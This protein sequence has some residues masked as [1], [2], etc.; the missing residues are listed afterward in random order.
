MEHKSYDLELELKG[1]DGGEFSAYFATFHDVDKV[2]DRIEPGAFKNLDDFV[3]SGW[4]GLNHEHARLPVAY[5]VSAVQ[6]AKGLLVTGRYHSTP[7]AQ[8]VR[9]VVRER[10]ESGKS[11]KGSIGYGVI[12][13]TGSEKI[14]V[15]GKSVRSLKE[16]DLAECS[17]VNRPANPNAEVVHSKSLIS[18]DEIREYIDEIKAG[19]VLS[20]ANLSV[21]AG[22]DNSVA[23]LHGQIRALRTEHD[24]ALKPIFDIP[25]SAPADVAALRTQHLALCAKFGLYP[26]SP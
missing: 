17:F 23:E 21:L 15:D 7:F 25:K 1:D 24:P 9:T 22:W 4:I 26:S 18:L 10:K 16:I 6:D 13:K 2:G 14:T 11:V 8:E 20:A 12:P 19:R 5:P 3:K